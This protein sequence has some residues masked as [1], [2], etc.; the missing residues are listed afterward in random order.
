MNINNLN[1]L[2]TI[3]FDLDGVLWNTSTI[4]DLAF[5]QTLKELELT[6]ERSQTLNDFIYTNYAGMS[7]EEAMILYLKNKKLYP[8]ILSLEQVNKL[9]KRKR[10]LALDMI[11]K[12][13]PL[14]FGYYELL[15]QLA[16]EKKYNLVLASSASEQSVD[17]FLKVSKCQPFFKLVLSS[18]DVTRAKPDPEIYLTALKKMQIKNTQ[19][20]VIEDAINGIKAA[21][22]AGLAVIAI[23]GTHSRKELE[24]A[25][26]KEVPCSFGFEMLKNLPTAASQ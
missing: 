17:Y 1:N 20:I 24:E 23:E 14:S 2:N 10:E 18:K 4:H 5:K 9:I 13:P 15:S 19:A 12:D 22:N 11:K 3:I 7:T 16:L 25:G 21:I 8:D 6:L 26:F